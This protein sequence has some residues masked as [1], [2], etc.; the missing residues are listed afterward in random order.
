[1]T[2]IRTACTVLS[3][4]LAA[5]A[6]LADTWV[7]DA[8]GGGDFTTIQAAI[9][10]AAPGDV[11]LVKAGGYPGFT[12]GKDLS[13]LGEP[14]AYPTATGFCV[15]QGDTMSI[16]GLRFF[17]LDVLDAEGLVLLDDIRFQG[18][19]CGGLLIE[20]CAQVHIERSTIDGLDGTPSCE[21]V[22]LRVVDS[23]VTVTGSTLTGGTGWGDDFTGY[24]GMPGLDIYG[25]SSVLVSGT[26]VYGGNG[27]TPEILFGGQG[28]WGSEAIRMNWLD[29]DAQASCTVRGNLANEIHGGVGGQGIGGQDA[30]AAVSGFGALTLSGVSY[31]PAFLGFGLTVEVPNPAQPFLHLAGFDEP[32][33]FKR[34]NMFGPAN[35]PLLVFASLAAAQL[36]APGPVDGTIWL[37][38]GAPLLILPVTLMGQ[39][40]SQNFT[41]QLPATLT[42]LEGLVVTFQGFASGMGGTGNYLASNPAHLLVR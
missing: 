28:G 2:A 37:D 41:F 23:T 27:G 35:Q 29:P 12:L 26:D 21:S 6:A 16:A 7:V 38:P 17:A 24:P 15:L 18:G 33:S 42:G 36:S 40:T 20:D 8:G 1:M 19:T 31:W 13:I 5:P 3:L 39:Q 22:G 14:G 10:A 4:A 32:G 11:L 9:N 25:T 30:F 34:L